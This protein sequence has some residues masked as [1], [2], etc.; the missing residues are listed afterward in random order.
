[1][2]P[3]PAA[4]SSPAAGP[5]PRD[6]ARRLARAERVLACLQ[7]SL[8][9]DL[10]SQL[11]AIQG[12]LQILE[13]EE[14]PRLSPDGQDYVRRLAA[15]ARRAQALVST[16]RAIGRAAAETGP[17]EE[18]SLAELAR[19]VIAE[20]KSGFPNRAVTYHLRLAGPPLRTYRQHL[21]RALAEL[22]RLVLRGGYGL[23][24][25]LE[26]RSCPEGVLLTVGR[27]LPAPAEGGEPAAKP[28]PPPG[29]PE[30]DELPLALVREL[31][32]TWGGCLTVHADPQRGTLFTILVR[33]L[34]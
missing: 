32:D 29:P 16:L 26:S 5:L 9:H 12:L 30:P 31:A 18:V 7:H 4:P 13:L 27:H 8:N 2:D 21:H 3:S 34:P 23:H 14:A 28:S 15:T 11:V 17:P 20:L 19:E 33:P 22:L 10:P 25:L 6:A 24:V 1:M